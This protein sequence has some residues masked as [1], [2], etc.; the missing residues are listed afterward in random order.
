M[1]TEEYIVSTE[2]EVCIFQQ[3]KVVKSVGIRYYIAVI[4]YLSGRSDGI[5]D[6][7]LIQVR[8]FKSGLLHE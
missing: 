5:F 1:R 2:M 8:S 4:V 6:F 3:F 7:I